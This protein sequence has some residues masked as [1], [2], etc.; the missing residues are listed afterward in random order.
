MLVAS[1]ALVVAGG[2][3]VSAQLPKPPELVPAAVLLAGA[4]LLLAAAVAGLARQAVF[5]W[6]RFRQVGGWA[7]CAYVVVAGMLEYVFVADGAR[8]PLLTVISLMLLVFAVD[9]PCLLGFSVARYQEQPPA[10]DR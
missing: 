3:Y 6:E 2:I 7:L 1:M 4:V 8:G 5:A 9:V 10:A